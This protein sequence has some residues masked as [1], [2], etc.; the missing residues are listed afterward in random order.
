MQIQLFSFAFFMLNAKVL[1]NLIEPDNWKHFLVWCYL[2]RCAEKE[3][4]EVKDRESRKDV[5]LVGHGAAV[6]LV[7]T[8]HHHHIDHQTHH[9]NPKHQAEQEGLLPSAHTIMHART[10]T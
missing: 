1:E 3:E 6:L 4:G 10:N 5:L 7:L 9:R 8:V 2:H